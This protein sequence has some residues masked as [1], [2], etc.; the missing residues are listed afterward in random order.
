M[1]E[2]EFTFQTH[3]RHVTSKPKEKPKIETKVR[4]VK[5]LFKRETTIA[6][7]KKAI[8][9]DV[10]PDP[11]EEKKKEEDQDYK[12]PKGS[13]LQAPVPGKNGIYK[14]LHD[15][16]TLKDVEGNTIYVVEKQVKYAPENQCRVPEVLKQLPAPP[17]RPHQK[18]PEV[19]P[20]SP[21]PAPAPRAPA[22][23]R[24]APDPPPNRQD[25]VTVP[26][27]GRQLTSDYI[28]Q[29]IKRFWPNSDDDMARYVA[30][31]P[32]VQQLTEIGKEQIND[33]SGFFG[34]PVESPS[35]STNDSRGSSSVS[36]NDS[37]GSSSVSTN[38]SR[39][40][41]SVST[42]ESGDRSSTA[43]SEHGSSRIPPRRRK[44]G[45][46]KSNKKKQQE[47]RE[48]REAR[49][50][51]YQEEEN[52]EEKTRARIREILRR[53]SPED[54]SRMKEDNAML[55]SVTEFV[56]EEASPHCIV[57][58]GDWFSQAVVEVTSQKP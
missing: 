18:P 53:A 16:Q 24:T 19:T 15:T 26:Q 7:V 41:S 8:F 49:E 36:T 45:E 28:F 20:V 4:E 51:Q 50:K 17:E 47:A 2:D 33:W 58:H 57:R 14:L 6:D 21:A 12:F 25:Q 27:R 55:K 40:S 31:D 46:R 44:H 10:Y 48:A 13:L 42:N 32:T 56:I 38:D 22:E 23:V 5:K 30:N 52:N 9:T 11:F 29:T 34:P 3:Y 43:A 35:V 54:K 1:A 37:R 39:G